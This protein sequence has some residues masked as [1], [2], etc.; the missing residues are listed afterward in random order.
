MEQSKGFWVEGLDGLVFRG[1][2]VK[3]FSVQRASIMEGL[4]FRVEGLG[5]MGLTLR[6][7]SKASGLWIQAPGL[8]PRNLRCRNGYKRV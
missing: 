2:G 6:G 3:G 5:F 7:L 4:G 8:H 1:L